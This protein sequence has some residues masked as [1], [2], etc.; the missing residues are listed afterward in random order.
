MVDRGSDLRETPIVVPDVNMEGV[1]RTESKLL[2]YL[3]TDL[4]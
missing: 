2:T 3:L 4:G 1:P